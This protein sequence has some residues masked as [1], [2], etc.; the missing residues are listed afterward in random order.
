MAQ[1][2]YMRNA[3]GYGSVHKLS[4]KRRKPWRV[5]VT[6]GWSE[7]G[8]QLFENVGYC[9]TRPE[10]MQLL[11]RYNENPWDM[12]NQ[13]ITFA[14]LFETWEKKFESVLTDKN[15]KGYRFAYQHCGP[16]YNTVFQEIRT[17]HMQK[18]IDDCKL[19]LSSMNRIKI[20]FSQLYK[21]A[22]ENDIV[23]KNY[24]QFILL[25]KEEE[26][27]EKIPF[28]WK[29]INELWDNKNYYAEVALMLLFSGMRVNELLSVKNKDV[30]LE[31]GYI[32]GGSKTKAG[33]DRVIPIS[34]HTRHLFEKWYNPDHELLMTK[35]NRQTIKYS[36]LQPIW[37]RN[38]NH[39][40]HDTR[41][42]FISLADSADLNAVSLKRIVGHASSNITE[43]VYTHKSIEELKA[44]I[45]KFDLYCEKFI[46]R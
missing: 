38:I 30:H 21:Y 27:E 1:R 26:K 19:S 40:I 44:T 41:H 33:R 20:L 9:E 32:T 39:P 11:A 23:N 5:R 31:E 16:L 22:I 28:T 14:N 37:R 25:P 12:N 18:I 15:L 2:K 10:A 4:G 7:D 35:W 3:N 43:K 6:K 36:A 8:K 46:Q 45:H 17:P 29:E 24:S 34:S 42:T 13:T